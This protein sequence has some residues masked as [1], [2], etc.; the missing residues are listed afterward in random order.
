MNLGENLSKIR[1]IKGRK[2]NDLAKEL[3]MTQSNYSKHERKPRLSFEMIEKAAKVLEVDPQDIVNFDEKLVFNIHEVKE[4]NAG[5]LVF[6]S[7]PEKLIELYEARI[8]AQEDE[9]K[10]LRSLL[11]TLNSQVGEK[12]N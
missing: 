12:K 3:G 8:Q 2:Q 10:L 7:L 5:G 1:K 4:N 9:I 6:N 11:D